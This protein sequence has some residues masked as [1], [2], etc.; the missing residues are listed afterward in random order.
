[1]AGLFEEGGIAQKAIGYVP[2]VGGVLSSLFGKSEEDIRRERIAQARKQNEQYRQMAANRVAQL[3]SGGIKDI[4]G[5]TATQLGRA[6][7]DIGRRAAAT[8]RAGDTEA[9][10]LPVTSNIN[11]AGGKRMEDTLQYYD[12]QA[13]NVQSQFDKNAMDIESDAAAR[14]IE[15]SPMEQ[16]AGY[17]SSALK[18]SNYDKYL[19]AMRGINGNSNGGIKRFRY[20]SSTDMQEPIYD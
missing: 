13:A 8:G 11:E 5:E 3:K 12:T 15:V 1:M 2:L 9:M 10:M 18:Q 17:A 19:D 4:S 6:Q 7:S 20:N 16:I 14:P